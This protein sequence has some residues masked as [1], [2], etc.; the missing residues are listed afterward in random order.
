MS[1][2]RQSVI[3]LVITG[4]YAVMALAI[5]VLGARLMRLEEFGLYS[6]VMGHLLILTAATSSLPQLM[7]REITS[8]DHAGDAG[9]L[10]GII[11]WSVGWVLLSTLVI[12]GAALV[13]H[14]AGAGTA[15]WWAVFWIGLPVLAAMGLVN[16]LGA[17]LRALDRPILSQIPGAVI[18]P[19]LQIT[20]LLAVASLVALT[21][22]R[23]MLILLAAMTAATAVAAVLLAG[24][25]RAVSGARPTYRHRVWGAA[26]MTIGLMI[27]CQ[28]V[29]Q[30]LGTVMLQYLGTLDQVAFYQPAVEALILLGLPPLA[31]GLILMPRF[32]RALLEED[33]ALQQAL[34]RQAARLVWLCTT[35]GAVVLIAMGPSG[36]A[37]VFG[38]KFAAAYPGVAIVAAGQLAASTLGNPEVLLAQADR[39]RLVARIMA[40]GVALNIALS[41]ALIPAFGTEGAA[42]ATAVS[43]LAIRVALHR[44]CRRLLGLSS[45]IVDRANR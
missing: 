4:G 42:A 12:A 14:L 7:V 38:A 40:A 26:L 34:V 36:L 29:N 16:A 5:S 28:R 33:R 9:A 13:P 21:A 18:R 11:R 27:A 15:A 3:S 41:A 32:R 45:G 1:F 37:A 2:T 25:L 10:T 35:A 39:E 17:A 44:A 24:R 23:A 19:V 30:H 22:Q 6:S 20:A 43:L 8:A 31:V